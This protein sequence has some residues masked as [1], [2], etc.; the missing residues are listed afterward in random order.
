MRPNRESKVLVNLENKGRS[1][2]KR[3][4][5]PPEFCPNE[6]YV[7]IRNSMMICGVDKSLVG[8]GNKH[9]LFYVILRDYGSFEAANA[10]NRLSKLCS[11]W[12]GEPC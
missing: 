7:V 1:F 4:G 2:E 10:M 3:E 5:K 8:D 6:G 11:G 9:S 12:L